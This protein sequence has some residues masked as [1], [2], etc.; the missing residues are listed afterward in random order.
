MRA[1]YQG[2][3]V[4]RVQGLTRRRAVLHPLP[5]LIRNVVV[6]A[7]S[8]KERLCAFSL[9]SPHL[10]YLALP[11]TLVPLLRLPLHVLAVRL[12]LVTTFN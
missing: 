1:S 10:D 4:E 12:R 5:T 3:V 2:K 8:R 9:A 6:S 11:S 7:Q